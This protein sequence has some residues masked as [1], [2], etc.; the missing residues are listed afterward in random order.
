M[1]FR[2]FHE[3]R[4]NFIFI[5]LFPENGHKTA[6]RVKLS[7]LKCTPSVI[8]RYSNLLITDCA[9]P[10]SRI[11]LS[12][13]IPRS[14]LSTFRLMDLITYSQKKWLKSHQCACVY[15]QVG[16]SYIVRVFP[17][18]FSESDAQ[19]FC[20]KNFAGDTLN[21][22]QVKLEYLHATRFLKKLS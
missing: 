9:C 16:Y 10:L 14:S 1:S 2:S 6:G 11:P 3:Q 15:F 4:H 21:L 13:S 5:T 8:K 17:C 19:H 22:S 20:G 18:F 12:K 7:V